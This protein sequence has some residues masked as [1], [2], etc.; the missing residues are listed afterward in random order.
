MYVPFLVSTPVFQSNLKK[1]GK[2]GGKKGKSDIPGSRKGSTASTEATALLSV[3]PSKSTTT[4]KKRPARVGESFLT[5]A[6]SSLQEID[7]LPLAS[8]SLKGMEAAVHA[9]VEYCTCVTVRK[10]MLLEED[11]HTLL[12]VGIKIIYLYIW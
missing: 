9:L 1:M 2:K 5:Q 6:L 4:A 11:L 3:L 10:A 12:Q 7:S 8:L